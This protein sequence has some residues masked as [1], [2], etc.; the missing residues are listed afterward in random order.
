MSSAAFVLFFPKQV[1]SA[2][3][4]GRQSADRVQIPHETNNYQLGITVHTPASFF[5]PATQP[6][7]N[8]PSSTN[9]Q[10]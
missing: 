2:Q 10:L 8:K 1:R 3:G 5:I 4:V 7:I 6:Y 9:M